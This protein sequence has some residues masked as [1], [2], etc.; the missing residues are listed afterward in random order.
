MGRAV[1]AFGLVALDSVFCD[2]FDYHIWNSNSQCDNQNLHGGPNASKAA[3]FCEL[4]W[5][6][7]TCRNRQKKNNEG[8]LIS[9]KKHL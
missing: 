4:F 5:L 2:K 8:G 6:P 1:S 3:R 7:P 9:Q